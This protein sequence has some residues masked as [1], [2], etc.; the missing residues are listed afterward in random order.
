MSASWKHHFSRFLG[1]GSW[2][3]AAA[4]SHHPWPDISFEAQQQAWLDAAELIDGKWDL[5]FSEVLPQAQ[6]HLARRLN[7]PA[8]QSL[9]FAGNT[10][11]F[12]LRLLSCIEHQPVR[13]L[14]TDGE[15]H[16]FSRQLRRLEQAGMAQADI[17][18]IELNE[19]FAAQALAVIRTLDLDAAKVNPLGG[20]IALGHPL[21]ATGAIRTATVIAAMQRGEADCAVHSLKAPQ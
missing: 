6:R 21:G 7:L 14:S 11:E 20:A 5:I 17:D 18:W 15:F 3:H 19:A 1:A 16:S 9:C 4:H 8:P 13:V 12:L 10:H 2:L